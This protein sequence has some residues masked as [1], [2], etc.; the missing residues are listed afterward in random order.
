MENC[1]KGSTSMRTRNKPHTVDSI[2]KLS[3]QHGDCFVWQS[4]TRSNGYGVIVFR[5]K[6]TTAHRAMFELYHNVKLSDNI[7]VDHACNNRACVSPNH[8]EAV[9]HEENMKRSADRRPACKAGHLW[10][11]EN[12]YVTEVNRKQGGVRYQRYCRTCRAQH[13][14]D[15][16]DRRKNGV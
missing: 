13:Q 15:L 8:L 14:A 2:L 16:R 6:Q 5:G 9:S 10:T 11:D 3:K 12:T 4:T 1:L 7:E